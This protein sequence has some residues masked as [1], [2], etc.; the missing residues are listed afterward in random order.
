[1]DLIFENMEYP[2]MRV[3][4]VSWQDSAGPAG[5]GGSGGAPY[6]ISGGAPA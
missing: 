3:K 4:S 5:F 2:V 6:L 1:M